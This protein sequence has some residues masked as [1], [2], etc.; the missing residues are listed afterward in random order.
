MVPEIEMP[1]HVTSVLVAY[2]QFGCGNSPSLYSMDYPNINYGF[3]LLSI[4]TPATQAFVKDVLTEVMGIFPGKYIHCGGDEVIT[5]SG[6]E[7]S[8]I[9]TQWNSYSADVTNMQAQGITPDGVNSIIEYQNWFSTFLANYLQSNG[10]MMIGWTETELD[11]AITNAAVMDWMTIGAGAYAAENG[12]PVVTSPDNACYINYVE[13]SSSSLAYEPPFVVGGAPAYTTLNTVYSFN[14]IPAGLAPQYATNIL[15]AQCILFGEYVPSFRNVM[16][17]M[18]PRETAMAEVTWTPLASQNFSSFT[19]RLAMQEQRFSQM[20]INYD[21]E[22]IPQIGTWGPTVSTSST[23]NFYDITTNVTA[24]GEIDISFWY[25]NG[26]PLSI[27]SVAL[28]V[29]GVQVD[30]DAHAGLAES[31]STY[32]ATQPF[33]P[34]F[35]LYVLHLPEMKLG[36]TYT[37]KTVTQGFGGTATS[38]IIYLPNWN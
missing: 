12:Q 21:H 24:A 26:S 5:V 34:V 19:N 33:I 27:S 32:Q 4:G 16:F 11:G 31:S 14:P 38:G 36:A 13:G 3:D 15:G 22:S 10:R 17:K 30:I 20:G 1:A 23:T 9:D 29:N 2:P 28:L 37:V 25:L 35:T 7:A 6:D 8:S 18:F